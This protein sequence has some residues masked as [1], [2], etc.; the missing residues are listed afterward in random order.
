MIIYLVHVEPLETPFAIKMEVFNE[1][2]ILVLLYG[3]ML[4][5]PYVPDPMVRY[6]LGWVYIVVALTNIFIHVCLIT[7]ESGKSIKEKIKTKCCKGRQLESQKSGRI[8][9]RSL[10]QM[11][12][13]DHKR[14]D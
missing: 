5:T 13:D 4:F 6:R 1:C 10:Q 11:I 12:K 3:L 14:E 7:L 8:T 9:N 2:T